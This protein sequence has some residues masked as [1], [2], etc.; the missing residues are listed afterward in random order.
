MRTHDAMVDLVETLAET[1]GDERYMDKEF[2]LVRGLHEGKDPKVEVE[3][4]TTDEEQFH[5]LK[6]LEEI[7]QPLL[8]T[9]FLLWVFVLGF[10]F[11]AGLAS[12]CANGTPL[13]LQGAVALPAIYQVWRI[14]QLTKLVSKTTFERRPM[15]RIMHEF[16]GPD[17]Y[18]FIT[19]IAVADMFGRF[20]RALFVGFA[21]KC[22][23]EINQMLVSSF[24]HSHRF[25][26][27]T[28]VV[29][30]F[31][32]GW[33]ALMI[34]VVG[35]IF[36]RGGYMLY[37]WTV[38][39]RTLDM[40]AQWHV[41]T[42]DQMNIEHCI[43][44]F[45]ALASW[46]MLDPICKVFDVASLPEQ[47]DTINDAKRLWGRIKTK[48]F[49]TLAKL[50]PDNILFINLQCRFFALAFT[51]LDPSAKVQLMGMIALNA[52]DPLSQSLELIGFNR[53]LTSCAGF[54][55]LS[56]MVGPFIRLICAFTCPS[57]IVNL[58]DFEC[59]AVDG[60]VRNGTS[61]IPT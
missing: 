8:P 24:R 48:V 59:A 43:D 39:R 26:Y 38:V 27:L 25:S 7:Y 21:L 15:V 1:A 13:P 17:N 56:T 19:A 55:L 57:H 10:G 37:C 44:E 16:S 30:R 36:I 20:S 35:P 53:R 54:M 22:D 32:L 18:Y 60:T 11:I 12:D 50:I 9:G 14:N 3:Q 51:G 34:F 52:A 2:C 40:S 58:G 33:T 47:L 45:G 41:G 4:A 49:V 5:A 29:E 6:R 42:A 61:V 28:P 46:S 31:G 23:D